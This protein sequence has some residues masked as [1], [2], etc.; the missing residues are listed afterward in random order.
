MTT[1]PPS[2]TRTRLA[3]HSRVGVSPA[4]AALTAAVIGL[5]LPLAAPAWAGAADAEESVTWSIAPADADG[6][7]GRVSF[8]F[9]QD[10]RTTASGYVQ[11]TNLSERELT[12]DLRASDGI[13]GPDGAFDVLP[14][15]QEPSDIGSWIEIQ[16]TVTVAALDHAVVPFTIEIPEDALPGDHPG[17]IVASLSPETTQSLG[18]QVGLDARIGARI[19]MRISGEIEATLAPTGL[20]AVYETSWNP[21]APG[22]VHLSYTMTNGGN[23]RLG[24]VQSVDVVGLLPALSTVTVDAFAE[25]REVLPRHAQDV[26]GTIEGVWP[27]GSLDVTVLSANGLVGEDAVAA[28][29]DDALAAVTVAAIPWPQLLTLIVVAGIVWLLVR[30]ARIRRRRAAAALEAARAEGAAAAHAASS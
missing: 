13:V 29:I 21:F 12:F 25:Q 26:E 3:K 20:E 8:R 4:L 22:R 24:S 6:A 19:H 23:V 9:A 16:P 14:S 5:V 15:S 28:D 2:A 17:G 18:S 11:V 30:R 10:P 7:D 27:W 1:L